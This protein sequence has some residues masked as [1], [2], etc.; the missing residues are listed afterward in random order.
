MSSFAIVVGFVLFLLPSAALADD[1]ASMQLTDY[2]GNILTEDSEPVPIQVGT[3]VDITAAFR[4]AAGDVL[5]YPTPTIDMT[6]DTSTDCVEV[7]KGA[8]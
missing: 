3:M 5:G 4:N 6:I 7:T 2:R 8:A 1:V